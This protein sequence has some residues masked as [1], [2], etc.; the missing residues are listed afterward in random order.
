LACSAGDA[1]RSAGD[2]SAARRLDSLPVRFGT[3]AAVAVAAPPMSTA[4]ATLV[5]AMVTFRSFT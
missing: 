3:G 5:A 4:A 1:P 2:A